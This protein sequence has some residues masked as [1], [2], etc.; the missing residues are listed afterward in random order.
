MSVLSLAD[1]VAPAT[2]SDVLG[3]ELSVAQDLNLPTTA[4]QPLGQVRT[5]L[6]TSATLVSMY[7]ST[8]NLIA[9]GGYASYAALM[10]DANG[11]PITSWMDLIGTNNYNEDRVQAS[12]ASGPVPVSNSLA[13]S[14]PYTIGQLRFQN[15]ATGATYSNTAVGTV[16]AS[17]ASTIQVQ[18]DQ[19]WLGSQGTSGA[20]I[21]LTMLT[22]LPGVSVTA[23]TTSLVGADEETNAAYLTRCQ[24]KLGTLS[25]LGQINGVPA[26]VSPGGAPQSYEFVATSIPQAATASPVWPYTVT[27]PITRCTVTN[28]PGNVVVVIANAEGTPPAPDTTAVT[29]AL[30]FLCDPQGVTL[31]VFGATNFAIALTLTVYV[32][33]NGNLT[34]TQV[35][36]NIEDD[37]ATYLATV[38]IGGVTTSKPNILPRSEVIATIMGANASTVDLDL[39]PM[40]SPVSG[41]DP[42]VAD[43]QLTFY[44]VPVLGTLTITVVFV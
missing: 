17:G 19:A 24:N 30:Q 9:Q 21:V 16:S 2:S 1:L 5:V 43:T 28:G 29:N 4:W 40:P 33:A 31:S 34:S 26:P 27:S 8:V 14:Y 6:A 18:A 22:P 41:E 38:K 42:A 10:V 20:G 15:P 23:L 44:Q 13:T 12:A 25:A 3:I 36:A 11:T 7:S 32:R 37:L 35:I 39:G